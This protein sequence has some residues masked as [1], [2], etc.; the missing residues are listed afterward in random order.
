MDVDTFPEIYRSNNDGRTPRFHPGSHIINLM[1]V[2]HLVDTAADAAIRATLGVAAIATTTRRTWNSTGSWVATEGRGNGQVSVGRQVP[3]TDEQR[4]HLRESALQD[5]CLACLLDDTATSVAML[6]HGAAFEDVV[7]H[8]LHASPHNKHAQY[9]RVYLDKVPTNMG[10][11][12]QLTPARLL[13]N[14]CRTYGHTAAV[15]R[16]RG[17]IRLVRGDFRG[18]IKDLSRGIQLV[19]REAA[20]REN[21]CQKQRDA[22]EHAFQ[23]FKKTKRVGNQAYS[24]FHAPEL[25]S[26]EYLYCIE[27]QLRFYRGQAY[28]GRAYQRIQV[29]MGPAWT[30][31]A[32]DKA[33]S[34]RRAADKAMARAAAGEGFGWEGVAG[35]ADQYDYDGMHA[36][37]DDEDLN[38]YDYDNVEADYDSDKDHEAGEADGD[39][40]NADDGEEEDGD[41][42]NPHAQKKRKNVRYLA[43]RA[44]R[45]FYNVLGTLDFAFRVPSLSTEIYLLRARLAAFMVSKTLVRPP[46]PPRIA[47]NNEKAN[48]LVRYW[49]RQRSRRLGRARADIEAID[50]EGYDIPVVRV[51]LGQAKTLFNR[52]AFDRLPPF[53]PEV[54]PKVSTAASP[55][56]PS[57]NAVVARAR[58]DER[59]AGLHYLLTEVATFHPFLDD[60]LHSILMAHCLLRTPPAELMHQINVVARLLRAVSGFPLHDNARGTGRH[61]WAAVLKQLA[62]CGWVA[63][64]AAAT[65]DSYTAGVRPVDRDWHDYADDAAILAARLADFDMEDDSDESDGGAEIHNGGSAKGKAP[66]K[67]AP[68]KPAPPPASGGV[69]A[70]GQKNGR[71][72][73][74]KKAQMT[75]PK[76]TGADGTSAY[77]PRPPP[78][79]VV[80]TDRVVAATMWML[81]AVHENGGDVPLDGLPQGYV[82][83]LPQQ[84]EAEVTFGEEGKDSVG[85]FY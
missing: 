59:A 54:A 50:K 36:D 24:S 10:G 63:L 37:E 25:K 18:A 19:A 44:M 7:G 34:P 75:A 77:V 9:V 31:Y 46:P 17:M 69:P 83:P 51:A 55:A 15:W 1:R 6:K 65:W 70:N 47:V 49:Q 42:Y 40:D 33:T 21:S 74:R 56:P 2:R 80:D 39:E 78:T 66:E 85:G 38:D 45:D 67:A 79:P 4:L 5:L 41:E 58:P 73:R 22:E 12:A 81:Q 16:T 76:D 84:E 43:R 13:N 26:I 11:F 57:S 48:G 32:A 23:E 28:I 53:P 60:M 29:A 68:A 71:K 82:H 3:L 61:D 14:L 72:N 20:R 62:A 64:P 35:A 8:V 27:N 52:A 30:A